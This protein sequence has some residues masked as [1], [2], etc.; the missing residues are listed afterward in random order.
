MHIGIKFLMDLAIILLSTK[1]MGFISKKF[2]MPEVVGA[3]LAGI[4][5]GPIVLG[6]EADTEFIEQISKL[7][8]ILLMFMA[9]TETDLKELKKCGKASLVIAILGVVMPLIGGFVVAEIYSNVSIFSISKQQLLQNIFIGVILTA[10]SVSITVQTLQEMGKFKT[11]S[12]TAILGAAIIDDIL[13]IIILAI[14]SGMSD[15][16]VKISMVLLK[17]VGFFLV[18]AVLGYVF[19]KTLIMLTQKYESSNNGISIFSLVFCLIMAYLAEH[20]FGVA[21]IT[22]AYF[23]GI[24]VACTP[25]VK[26][27][28]EK[29]HPVSFMF[30]SPV[31]F[32]SIGIKTTVGR[33]NNHLIVF[34]LLLLLIAII[35]KLL[36]CGLGAKMCGYSNSE[37]IEIGTGMISRGEVA[38]I[39]ANIGISLGLMKTELFAPIIIV[40]IITTI[41]TPI[42][43]KLV[44]SKNNSSDNIKAA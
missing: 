35:T 5:I 17:I 7:G 16:S 34:T 15:P 43:L 22:G 9:G 11:P 42:F 10:T 28:E 31:F 6:I 4:I 8:V 13:G 44:Y 32:A 36:G 33:M 3:L 12:G 27:I 20:Y 18:A 26:Q 40:V 1:I 41:V 39:V 2:G 21:D 19:Y 37:A 14:V 30:L 24:S 25:F 38:L 23:A 29:I